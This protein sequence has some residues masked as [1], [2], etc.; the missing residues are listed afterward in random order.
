MNPHE[1][2]DQPKHPLAPFYRA[3]GYRTWSRLGTLWIDAGR[4]SVISVP[5]SHR[6]TAT[7]GEVERFVRDA[8]RI[9]AQF[10]TT[11]ATG[12]LRNGYWVRDRGY[13]PAFLQRQFRRQVAAHHDRCEVRSIEWRDLATSGLAI[14]GDARA[15]QG[16]PGPATR[17]AWEECCRIASGIP[18]LS[19]AA[20]T[21]DGEP[22][23]FLVAWISD[24]I[25]Y[26]LMYYR[27][28]RFDEF[29]P[30]HKLIAGFTRQAIGRP[31]VDAVTL[32]RD[33]VPAQ[34]AVG[35]FKRHAGF[36]PEPIA[37]AAV[38]DP[39]WSA[40]LTHGCTRGIL[41]GLHW[42]T[43]HRIGALGN[44]ELLDV[45]AVTRLPTGQR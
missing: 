14:I 8:G 27:W 2:H 33:L 7:R 6:V 9:A 32:G 42:L 37:V 18:G 3:W 44:V 15:R 5:C 24:R 20:C 16:C 39:R 1:P 29:R 28:A 21:V 11:A 36:R 26:V 41:H 38:L 43:G 45:A 12:V 31:D 22:A 34:G 13:G 10:P 30:S 17:D 19:A 25:C 23:A 40:L 35:A 4:F